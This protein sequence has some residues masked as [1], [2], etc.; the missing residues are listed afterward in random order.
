MATVHKNAR[1]APDNCGEGDRT[2]TATVAG[3]SRPSQRDTSMLGENGG[4]ANNAPP[5][6]KTMMWTACNQHSDWGAVAATMHAWTVVRKT[7]NGV[8]RGYNNSM[9]ILLAWMDVASI[10]NDELQPMAR[11]LFHASL[12]AALCSHWRKCC[13]EAKTL[14]KHWHV[15]RPPVA[16]QEYVAPIRNNM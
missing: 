9:H 14:R 12:P 13:L 1:R 3:A 7:G 10:N 5:T 15:C 16:P 2:T 6:A 8:G 11:T 4:R